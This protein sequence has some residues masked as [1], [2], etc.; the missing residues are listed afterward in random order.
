MAGACTYDFDQ[1]EGLAPPLVD[2]AGQG[3]RGGAGKDAAAPDG[4]AGKGGS[5][6]GGGSGQG[7]AG[8]RGGS[9]GMTGGSGG[10]GGTAGGSG[11]SA[12]TGGSGGSGAVGGS[13]G[14]GDAAGSAGAAGA[15]GSGGSSGTGGKIPDA[16]TDGAGG[17]G[18]ATG[19]T[20]GSAG[21]DGA[22]GA[23]GG[24][25]GT[26]AGAAGSAGAS[27]ADASDVNRPL[28]AAPDG[29]VVDI[30]ADT[31]FDCAA[32][33]GIVYQSHCYY[34]RSVA[35][36][37][38]TA[39]TTTCEAPAHLVTVTTAGE[40]AVVTALLPNQDRW[41]GLRR[42]LN[43]PKAE[44]SF[45]WVT[46]ELLS[47]RNWDLYSDAD[48][49]PNYTGECVRMRFTSMWADVA[50]TEALAVICEHD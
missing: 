24:T 21:T 34:A 14:S 47:Y 30:A 11:G 26:T 50:C 13:G 12:A 25:G 5:S 2:D 20:G 27:I 48:K 23:A 15:G 22:G 35:V 18:G 39:S 31:P 46:N 32:V 29:R 4:M 28:D 19:G 37:W 41:I 16:S 49:E 10:S 38:N 8:A 43:S 45:Y 17:T 7:G 36:D 9:G 40:Q 3:G 42:P 44:S 33:S 1:F 6:I